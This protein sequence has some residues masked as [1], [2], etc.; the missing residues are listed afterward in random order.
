MQ[1]AKKT[2]AEVLVERLVDFGVDTVFGLPGDG[3][4]G[5]TEAL[6]FYHNAI[7]APFQNDTARRQIRL[8]LIRFCERRTDLCSTLC[9]DA[10]GCSP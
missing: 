8:E 1:M 5:V 9:L 10:R 2:A 7:Y 4:N 6:R 3:I